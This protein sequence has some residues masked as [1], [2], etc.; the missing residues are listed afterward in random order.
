MSATNIAHS[1]LDAEGS[2]ELVQDDAGPEPGG[3]GAREA[4]RDAGLSALVALGLF[5]PMVGLVTKQN[6]QGTGLTLGW[7][8]LPVLVLVA[9]VF[10]GRFALV[11]LRARRPARVRAPPSR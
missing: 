10:A 5:L 1:G 3:G 4:L 8:P 2:R 11:L 9:L 6:Q 7:R